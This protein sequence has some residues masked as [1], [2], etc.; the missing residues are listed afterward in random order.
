MITKAFAYNKVK[1][2]GK[3][4]SYLLL[5]FYTPLFLVSCVDTIILPDDKTVDEDFWKSKSDVQLMV[6]GAYQAMLSQSVI[7]RLIVW[8][9]LRSDELVPVANE[10]GSLVEDLT[11]INLANIQTDNQF[12]KWAAIYAV[13]NKCNLVLTRAEAV[14]A[15]DPSYTEG[16]Y[17]ADCS[18][19]LGLRA[20]C[21]FYLVRNFRDV[22]YVTEAYMNS[23][24]ERNIPQAAPDSVLA[25]CIIDLQKAEQNAIAANAYADWRR[26]GYMTRDAIQSLLA[27]IY[28]WR[29]S[30]K[31][32]AA[33]YQACIDYCDKVIASKKSQHV[34]GRGEVEE[35]DF[36]L[37]E[38]RDAFNDLFFSQNAEESIFELQSAGS[39]NPNMA[40]C[41]YYDHHSNSGTSAPYLYAS[42]IFAN[43]ETVYTTQSNT[44]GK[45]D[46]R[47]QTNTYNAAVTVG[48][49]DALEVRKYV[50]NDSW[51]PNNSLTATPAK[52]RPYSTAY[53]Q[54]FIIYRLTDVMLMKAE[55]LAAQATDDEDEA[56]LR[57]AFNLAQV[58][59]ARSKESEAD[60]VKWIQYSGKAAI[61]EL[62]LAERLR[63]LAFEGKRWYDL[64]RYNYRH[65][66]AT[67][68]STTLAAMNDAGKSFPVTSNDM[69][70]LVKRKLS[71]KGDAV[72][73]KLGNEPKLYLPVP[74]SDMNV[75]PLLR[76]NPG[77]SDSDNYSKNY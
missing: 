41:L 36:Y 42:S 57:P 15:E 75:C 21:Y 22:P 62:V 17:L 55:A 45:K 26:V 3:K 20:L 4:V 31:N 66:T 32:S 16:D 35:K 51:S 5:L 19:M 11:E 1:A 33:D 2:I 59:N 48:D 46:W 10:S 65:T 38:G 40:V 69:L 50:C 18:Q 37:S 25:N 30:V 12:A 73:A 43:G 39:D 61:E 53:Q 70:N 8:G 60:S 7:E 14:M 74:L 52:N 64:L 28:L 9:G 44:Q 54:N 63:E 47:G 72:A 68:Y 13:I 34:L 24:Q 56:H 67:D 23:S 6:N 49:F 29:A 27:D 58:V 76:Q 77:Y 71:G